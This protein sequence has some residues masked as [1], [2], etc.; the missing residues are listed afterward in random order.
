MRVSARLKPYLFF[1]A[2]WL[3][4]GLGHFLQNKRAKAAVFFGGVLAMVGLGLLM[5]GGFAPFAGF[6][7]LS[8]LSFLGG[9]GSGVFYFAGK[10]AGAG[11]GNLWAYTYQ[12]GA[13][14]IAAAGFMNLLIALNA[15]TI[16]RAREAHRV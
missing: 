10:L 7:P 8:A 3:V 4:P 12:Y 11:V 16:V 13:A 9:V 1:T 15:A 14:Y 6:E 2:G 5:H